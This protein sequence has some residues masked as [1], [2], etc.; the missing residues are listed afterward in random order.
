M[1]NSKKYIIF[2]LIGL[3]FSTLIWFFMFKNLNYVT[4]NENI[5]EKIPNE[6]DQ[7]AYFDVNQD[8]I[9]IF[10]W[11]KYQDIKD[12][13]NEIRSIWLVRYISWDNSY[14]YILI[15]PSQNF[16]IK[17]A[18]KTI[19]ETTEESN[20]IHKLIDKDTIIYGDE[21]SIEYFN[22]YKWEYLPKNEKIGNYINSIINQ[23]YNIWF[24]GKTENNYLNNYLWK[25]NYNIGVWKFKNWEFDFDLEILSEKD[26]NMTK[27]ENKSKINNFVDENDL[28]IF[29]IF[30][31]LS[32]FDLPKDQIIN[33][34]DK[35]IITNWIVLKKQDY[36]NVWDDLS[37][38]IGI[39]I[40]DADNEIGIWIVI[41]FEWNN[42]FDTINTNFDFI[43]NS[44]KENLWDI[45]TKKIDDNTK[46]W[47]NISIPYLWTN[48]ENN[49]TI[50]KDNDMSIIKIL[51]PIIDEDKI[52]KKLKQ[53]KFS[54]VYLKLNTQN[55]TKLLEK[56]SI[57][58]INNE[59]SIIIDNIKLL[60]WK[61]IDMN[62]FMENNKIIL[63]LSI[64]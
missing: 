45:V 7:I 13:L 15:N 61:D 38:N 46:I 39:L 63:K 5:L 37:K 11:E 33:L 28:F 57:L 40:S 10:S 56:L 48:I 18:I 53:D 35:N 32:F 24:F 43:Y 55:I 34:L 51:S 4:Y 1:E 60:K 2:G 9:N 59:V 41:L 23:K 16:Y 31:I 29:N 14:Q 20:F 52:S 12:I 3:I 47:F 22:N 6:F 62:V 42:I 64:K 36:E 54:K 27:I 21:E 26:L 58:D 44:V 25:L 17:K 19:F 8:M 49:V 50:E 30:D